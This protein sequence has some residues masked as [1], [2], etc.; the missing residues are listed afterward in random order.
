MRL[1]PSNTS[2]KLP[3]AYILAG[4]TLSLPVTAASAGA[5]Q[6]RLFPATVY[7]FAVDAYDAPLAA[8]STY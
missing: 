5:T 4:E 8:T 2:V 1:L 6:V 7:G 3:R